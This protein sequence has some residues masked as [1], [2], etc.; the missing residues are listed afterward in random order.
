STDKNAVSHSTNKTPQKNEPNSD[1]NVLKNNLRDAELCI[2]TLES[3]LEVLKT[4]YQHHKEHPKEEPVTT[5]L[6][7]CNL[8]G[9]EQTI[10]L[11]KGE[12]SEAKDIQDLNQTVM[13]FIS[14]CLDANSIED[15]SLSIYQTLG[16]L[17]WFSGL[18]INLGTRSLEIDPSGLL[19][20]KEKTLI[21]NMRIDEVDSKDGGKSI[22]FHYVHISGKL[23][24]VDALPSTNEKQY[25]ILNLLQTS[26]K[27][28]ARM[29]ADQAYK[30]Q[31]K[32]LHESTNEIKKIAHEVDI[33]IDTL[34]KRTKANVSSGFGQ[35]QDIARSK[36]LKASQIASFKNLEQQTLNEI[37]ADNSLRLKVKKQFLLALKKL[38]DIE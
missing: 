33:A 30:K 3:E 31:R 26:D 38:E 32:A 37:S 19:Q 23:I 10:S 24:T 34:N 13:I 27:I 20:A 8:A 12:I 11:L 22:R 29:R 7:D 21:K 15:I 18:L 16:D 4:Q 17:G 14:E 6:S 5:P 9:L 1:V 25:A 36:G 35:I 28:I 2:D